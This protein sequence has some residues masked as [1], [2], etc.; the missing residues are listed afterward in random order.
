MR[1]NAQGFFKKSLKVL[2]EIE[3]EFDLDIYSVYDEKKK[4]Q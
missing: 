2:A 1:Y 4:R 3:A